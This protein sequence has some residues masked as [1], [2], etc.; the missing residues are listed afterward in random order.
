MTFRED[1]VKVTLALS[2]DRGLT[3]H[4]PATPCAERGS[5]TR[6]CGECR[7]DSRL[8]LAHSSNMVQH[9]CNLRYAIEIAI[10]NIENSKAVVLPKPL[11]AQAGLDGVATAF[12]EVSN[13]AI[14]LRKPIK[15]VR[16]GRAEGFSSRVR[17]DVNGRAEHAA[18]SIG[19]VKRERPATCFIAAPCAHWVATCPVRWCARG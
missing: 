9:S 2:K 7:R 12:I 5:C 6:S 13:G 15:P 11:L 10:R 17:Q 16:P 19:G 1:G 18:G 14:V 3:N 4:P 8:S